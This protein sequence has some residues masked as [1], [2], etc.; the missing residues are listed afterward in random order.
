MKKFLIVLTNTERYDKHD[1]PTG[2]WL[3]ELTHFYDE[4][5][6]YGIEADFISPLGGYV[7]LDPYS[8]KFMDKVDYKWYSDKTFITRALAESLK[9]T[10][11]DPDDYFAIYYTGGHGVLWDFPD[12]TEIQQL[13]M[14]IYN[15]D[16]FV[17]AV[18]H[19]VVGLLNLKLE[20]GE[21]LIKNKLVTGFTNTEEFLSQKYTK[22]PFSTEQEMKNRGANYKKRRFFKSHAVSDSRI[23]TG[24][25][26]WSPR[27]VARLLIEE[28]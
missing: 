21:F 7:P 19:G 14:D 23:I 12:N 6:K 2:L 20:T 1:I 13:A 5:Q 17:T 18:C 10:G 16:G 11:I 28:M 8:M 24:Q 15:Q 22:V 25:N 4:I 3:S 27:E 26:P 9:P